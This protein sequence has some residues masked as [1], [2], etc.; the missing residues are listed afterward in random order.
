MHRYFCEPFENK[1][2]T[3]ACLLNELEFGVEFVIVNY[4][5]TVAERRENKILCYNCTTKEQA[6]L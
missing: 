2:R 4:V 6:D 5:I 3:Q 1:Y